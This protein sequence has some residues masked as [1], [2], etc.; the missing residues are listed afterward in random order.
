MLSSRAFALLVS[1][2]AAALSACA[3]TAADNASVTG[4]RAPMAAIAPEQW[5]AGGASAPGSIAS[6]WWRDFGDPAL[7]GLIAEALANN[8]DLR[9]AA[10]RVLGA[11]AEARIAGA[12]LWPQLQTGANGSRGRQVFVGFPTDAFGANAPCQGGGCTPA[13]S[14]P[15]S[16]TSNNFGVSLD[17]S[18]E[19]DLWGR[20]RASKTAASAEADAARIAFE[21]ARLSL[22]AQTAKAWFAF[23]E[24]REQLALALATRDSYAQSSG[25]ITERYERGTRSPLDVR[26][27][28]TEA[29][30]AEA[31]VAQRRSVLERIARQ[32]EVLVGRYPSAELQP[33]GALLHPVTPVPAGVPAQVLVR[34]PDL[35]EAEQR[36]F[37]ADRR[38]YAARASMLPRLAITGSAG[39]ISD[40][41]ADLLDGDF[42]VW[43]IAANL[44]QPVFQGGRL[45][46]AVAR[47]DA[48]VDAAMAAYATAA[49]RAFSEVENALADE[50]HLAVVVAA[51]AD[52]AEQSAAA[53]SLATERYFGGLEGYVTVLQAQRNSLEARAT[54]LEARRLLLETRIN[55]YLALGGGFTSGDV[56]VVAV[57]PEEPAPASS[58][59]KA[60]SS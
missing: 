6:D 54:L 23:V 8:H 34:R 2:C 16:S 37:A 36:V 58:P 32:L 3:M 9:Q 53:E 17:L 48:G 57:V 45:R 10:A 30:A 4:A 50:R 49:L 11:Q 38:L 21:G 60:P 46:G 44:V 52:A 18:W 7:D 56:A 31:R 15:L 14:G 42:A 43:T 19:L 20:I 40:D 35:A 47:A 29:A 59:L 22:A 26:L 39:S 28:L 12:D 24:A 27:S 41:V 5:V 25:L 13:P 55:L 33:T 51:L 1:A